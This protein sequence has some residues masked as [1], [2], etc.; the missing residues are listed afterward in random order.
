MELVA[1]MHCKMDADRATEQVHFLG[2]WYADAMIAVENQG[3]YGET[4]IV[5]LR[6]GKNGRPPYPKIYRYR[7]ESRPDEPLSTPYGF[8]MN[9]KTRPLVIA[10]T[11]KV[12]RDHAVPY[13]SEGLMGELWTFVTKDTGTSPRA[14]DGCNDDRVLCASIAFELYREFGHHPDRV[15]S[16]RQGRRRRK[17][18]EPPRSFHE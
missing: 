4:M 9:T 10:Q 11:S 16:R 12:L 7:P 17:S 8:P 3:G 2:R 15:K 18:F 5:L 13:I 1:E 14:E 6:D